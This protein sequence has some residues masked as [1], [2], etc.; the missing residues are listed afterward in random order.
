M[1]KTLMD[2]Y[3]SEFLRFSL[4]VLLSLLVAGFATWK[5]AGE[6]QVQLNDQS[7]R[8]SRHEDD[9]KVIYD[10]KGQIEQLTNAINQLNHRLDNDNNNPLHK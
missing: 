3:G 4:T 2:R 1:A 8:L 7:T 5:K 10:L 6:L 9:V